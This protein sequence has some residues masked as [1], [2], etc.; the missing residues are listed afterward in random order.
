[1]K[2]SSRPENDTGQSSSN[3]PFKAHQYLRHTECRSD[4]RCV[5]AHSPTP[6]GEAF[7][8]LFASQSSPLC[9][10]TRFL[11]AVVIQ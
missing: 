6:C 11:Y 1:M 7:V 2:L 5:E 9:I 8:S 4:I 10:E 3:K